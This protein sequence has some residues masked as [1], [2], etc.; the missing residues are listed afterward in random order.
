MEFN[1]LFDITCR[2]KGFVTMRD[3]YLN[4]N[5][6]GSPRPIHLSTEKFD[7]DP[8]TPENSDV[9]TRQVKTIEVVPDAKKRRKKF[10]IRKNAMEDSDSPVPVPAENDSDL[11][12][13]IEN[14]SGSR[15]DNSVTHLS[16]HNTKQLTPEMATRR[17]EQRRKR[18]TQRSAQ[19]EIKHPSPVENQI[20]GMTRSGRVRR[21]KGFFD[22]APASH[23]EQARQQKRDTETLN[24]EWQKRKE[25]DHRALK[26]E[27]PTTERPRNT[28]NFVK[29]TSGRTSR[30]EGREEGKK[31]GRGARDDV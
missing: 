8:V 26:F 16:Q 15:S 23:R 3:S 1:E 18:E 7:A 2:P 21:Q 14:S 29:Q 20:P 13:Q 6:D 30:K 10:R 19:I 5:A 17:G 4:R 11:P 9:E 27:T 31:E 28:Q 25:T 24:S 12:D 22:P